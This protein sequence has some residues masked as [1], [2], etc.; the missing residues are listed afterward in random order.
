MS[1][2]KRIPPYSAKESKEFSMTRS[3]SW[4]DSLGDC[5]RNRPAESAL[6]PTLPEYVFAPTSGPPRR[7]NSTK[8]HA[9]RDVLRSGRPLRVDADLPEPGAVLDKYRIEE[10]LGMGAFAAVYRATHMLLRIDVAI[11][12]LRPKVIAST[13]RT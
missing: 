13:T 12:M 9:V 4:D 11:K 7:R 6:S 10:V 5:F 2:R 1:G 8:F 3:Q